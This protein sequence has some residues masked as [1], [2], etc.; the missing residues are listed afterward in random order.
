MTGQEIN[1]NKHVRLEFGECVQTHKEHDNAM[2]DRTL[3]AICLGPT[4]SERGT[5]QFMCVASGAQITHSRWTALPMPTEVIQPVS[6]IGRLQGAPT[7]LTFGD[8]HA[9]EIEDNLTNLDDYSNDGSYQPSESSDDDDDF[10]FDYDE[11]DDY[12]ANESDDV[13]MDDANESGSANNDDNLA[14]ID[15]DSPESEESDLSESGAS[16]DNNESVKNT[17]VK[18]I[19]DNNND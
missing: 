8:Q 5:H 9:H 19:D 18:T 3:G 10:I 14:D 15:T 4:G 6:E 17:G 12:R 11:D 7:T 2:T 16:T 13:D 1:Y